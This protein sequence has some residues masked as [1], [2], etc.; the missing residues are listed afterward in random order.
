M[1]DGE[2]RQSVKRIWHPY[3]SWEEFHAGMWRRV[4]GDERAKFLGEAIR[5]TGDPELYGQWM[6]KVT[7]AWPMSCE[8]NL[9][10][11][12]QNRRAWI[13]HAACC[14]A[15]KC[16]EDI[17]RSAWGHL[18]EDQRMKANQKADFAI[19]T[20][21]RAHSRKN[22]EVHRHLETAWIPGWDS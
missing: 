18:S 13:G 6:L 21:E 12:G 4:Y 20:W 16:P 8:H 1:S 2:I 19:V 17:T 10:D 9:T 22:S 5:F 14:L 3:T 11:I 7:A 15:I